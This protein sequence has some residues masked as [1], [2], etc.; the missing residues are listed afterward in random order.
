[1]KE[2]DKG[3]TFYF[4]ESG[5]AIATKLVS[6]DSP[7]QT[8]YNYKEGDYFGELSLLRDTPRAASVIA[9]SDLQLVA[10][11]RFSFKRLLGPLEDL[12]KRNFAKYELFTGK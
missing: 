10:L 5:H 1:V 12:L 6:P 7:P 9:D 4:I 11:D 2:G 8:V 3:D